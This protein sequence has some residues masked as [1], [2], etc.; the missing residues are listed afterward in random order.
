MARVID[1]PRNRTWDPCILS[2]IYD[3]SAHRPLHSA[4]EIEIPVQ[5]DD[6][7]SSY[8]ETHLQ[9]SVSSILVT[10][11]NSMVFVIRI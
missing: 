8:E 3:T 11:M 7:V 4:T 6:K 5:R 9:N 2:Y 1:R 10:V